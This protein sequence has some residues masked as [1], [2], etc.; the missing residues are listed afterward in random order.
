M[1]LEEAVERVPGNNYEWTQPIEMRFNELLAG[2]RGDVAVKV[3][4]DDFEKMRMTAERIKSVLQGIEGRGRR[5]GR[6]D[7]RAPRHEYPHRPPGDRAVRLKMIDVQEV[8]AA[9]VGGREAGQVFEGDRRFDL[10]VRLPDAMRR[11]VDAIRN[12]PIPIAHDER[13]S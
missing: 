12:L 11:D 7:D 5:E 8:V 10:V 1:R 13:E 9:A 4:G 2:V 6:A 3:Y